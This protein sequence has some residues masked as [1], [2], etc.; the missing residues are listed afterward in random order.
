MISLSRAFAYAGCAS[1]VNSLWKADDRATAFI[2]KQF[3]VHLKSGMSKAK[4]LQEA[5]L[6]YLSGDAINKSPAYWAHLVLMGDETPLY[7][8]G[9]WWIRGERVCW[10]YWEWSWW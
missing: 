3:Y 4:A 2:L 9:N 7:R 6:D 1:T 10:Y 5:K 8:R